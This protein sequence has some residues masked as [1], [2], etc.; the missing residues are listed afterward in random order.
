VCLYLVNV[1]TIFTTVY[2]K[3]ELAQVSIYLTVFLL[4]YLTRH[5]LFVRVKVFVSPKDVSKF[6]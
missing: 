5:S 3:I 4:L 1:L 6:V 2:I